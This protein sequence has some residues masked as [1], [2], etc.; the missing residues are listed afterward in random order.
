VGGVS[1]VM[2][3]GDS[4]TMTSCWAVDRVDCMTSLI[5][6]RVFSSIR[7]DSRFDHLLLT[8]EYELRMLN[9]VT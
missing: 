7:R 4:C 5:D 3:R 8:D 9:S 6:R 1:D 2:C